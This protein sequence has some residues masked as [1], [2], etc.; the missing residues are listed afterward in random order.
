MP[1]GTAWNSAS[2]DVNGLP[3]F[4]VPISDIC[5][6]TSQ[7]LKLGRSQP[8]RMIWCPIT[9]LIVGSEAALFTL[10]HLKWVTA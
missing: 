1:R 3:R 7:G 10:H 4:S 2:S 5:E 6:A 9:K 8:N